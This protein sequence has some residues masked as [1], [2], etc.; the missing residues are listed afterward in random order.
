MDDGHGLHPGEIA[1]VFGEV[2]ALHDSAARANAF[3][4]I[5]RL[6]DLPADFHK[7]ESFTGSVLERI[8]RMARE[9]KAGNA[10]FQRAIVFQPFAILGNRTAIAQRLSNEVI[11]EVHSSPIARLM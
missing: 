3:V 6:D 1:Q 4:V 8:E 5:I 2:Y 7:A 10:H 11:S 9:V